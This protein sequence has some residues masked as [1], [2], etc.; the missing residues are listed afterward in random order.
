MLTTFDE[1]LE[2]NIALI[3]TMETDHMLWTGDFN[4]HHPLWEDIRNCH[5]FNYAAANPL[6]DLIADHGMLQLLL[7]RI[8]T[9]QSVST[10][11]WTHLD[12]VFGMEH[13][14]DVVISCETAPELCSPRTDHLP[15]LLTLDLEAPHTLNEPCHNW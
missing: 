15:I 5:L 4:R 13:L 2:H 6:I 3:K 11:N 8:P 1:F 7:C 14:L 12:N 9:L 10:G